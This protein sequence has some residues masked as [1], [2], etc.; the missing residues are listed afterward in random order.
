MQ[1]TVWEKATK[2]RNDGIGLLLKPEYFE[3]LMIEAVNRVF[4]TPMVGRCVQKRS[5][6]LV[7]RVCVGQE[8]GFENMSFGFGQQTHGAS[9]S[10]SS[11]TSLKAAIAPRQMPALSAPTL[12]RSRASIVSRS[13]SVP[14]SLP[15]TDSVFSGVIW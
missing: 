3:A 2:P 9:V 1:R 10:G 12:S 14:Y 7:L 6:R 15:P 13:S 11:C 5:E 4:D 8:G